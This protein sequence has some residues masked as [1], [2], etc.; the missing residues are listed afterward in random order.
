MLVQ[1]IFFTQKFLFITLGLFSFR[2]SYAH[3]VRD[4]TIGDLDFRY[5][6]VKRKNIHEVARIK[7]IL[8]QYAAINRTKG[9]SKKSINTF[10][11]F[12]LPKDPNRRNVWIAKLKRAHLPKDENLNV[13]HEHFEEKCFQRDLRVSYIFLI[14]CWQNMFIA[15]AKIPEREGSTY[16]HPTFMGNCPTNCH[17]FS[18]IYP[19]DEFSFKQMMTCGQSKTSSSYFCVCCESRELGDR[20]SSRLPCVTPVVETSS[21]KSCS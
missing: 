20:W 7:K 6:T 2:L 17:V 19:V 14:D 13:C 10:S 11:F 4:V 8:A 16:H 5:V 3:L 1:N 15:S 12:K 9:S 18:L 21:D